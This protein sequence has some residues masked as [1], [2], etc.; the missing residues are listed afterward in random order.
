MYAIDRWKVSFKSNTVTKKRKK[1]K[2]KMS[3]KVMNNYLGTNHVAFYLVWLFFHPFCY[4][5]L[6]ML[7]VQ[8]LY[9]CFLCG[10]LLFAKR[11]IVVSNP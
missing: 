1:K 5:Y 4:C 3:P 2:N 11:F 7:A 6:L 8:G 10:V 9:S